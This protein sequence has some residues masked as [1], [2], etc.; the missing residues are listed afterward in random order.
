MPG[1]EGEWFEDVRLQSIEDEEEQVASRDTAVGHFFK[2]LEWF[3]KNDRRGMHS[4]LAARPSMSRGLSNQDFLTLLRDREEDQSCQG[5]NLY[6]LGTAEDDLEHC[7]ILLR[8]ALREARRTSDLPLASE[9][10]LELGKVYARTGRLDRALKICDLAESVAQ[11]SNTRAAKANAARLRGTVI[12]QWEDQVLGVK[13]LKR[14]ETYMDDPI[15]QVVAQSVRAYFEASSQLYDSA[16]RTNEEA[17]ATF[18]EL[19]HFRLGILSTMTN[20]LLK[21][22]AGSRP[23]AISDLVPLVDHY[24]A[25]GTTQFAV[26]AEELLAKLLIL[27]GDR[28]AAQ[29]YLGSAK[30]ARKTSQMVVTRLE[31]LRVS[32]IA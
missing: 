2:T 5:W 31:A 8:S 12:S 4:L 15:E 29:R 18:R 1:H 11:Q 14:A 16:A 9:A 24:Y 7:A 32:R 13:Y 22:A 19:G 20:V 28:G 27:D 23:Q 21:V 25:I 26:Y 30:R 17:L 6:W 10:C 3:A